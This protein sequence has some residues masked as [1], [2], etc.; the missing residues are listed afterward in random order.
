V[1]FRRAGVCGLRPDGVHRFGYQRG[2]QE[3]IMTINP[4][5]IA[6]IDARAEYHL[7]RITKTRQKVPAP[8]ITFYSKGDLSTGEFWAF[9]PGG[10]WLVVNNSYVLVGKKTRWERA[11]VPDG[12]E[13][14]ERAIGDAQ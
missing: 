9:A 5:L 1:V 10:M 12:V 7:T 2:F 4:Q 13:W 8:E 6:S 14:V 11:T 3:P